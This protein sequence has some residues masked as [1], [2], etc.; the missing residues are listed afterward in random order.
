MTTYNLFVPSQIANFQFQPTLDG[1]VYTV[2]V[3]WQ[4]FG[5][6]Y[7]FTLSDLQGNLI[8]YAPLIASPQGY[9]I[10]LVQQFGFTDAL[11]YRAANNSFESP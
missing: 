7:Y 5:Q 8:G 3:P 6:R 2:T 10:S 9:D 4:L 1:Q 11:V